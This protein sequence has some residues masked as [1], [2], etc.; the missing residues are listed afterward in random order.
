MLMLKSDL[1]AMTEVLEILANKILVI[2]G[3]MNGM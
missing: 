2:T 3:S 1:V